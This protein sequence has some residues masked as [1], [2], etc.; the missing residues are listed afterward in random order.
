MDNRTG[1]SN[2]NETPASQWSGDWFVF[3]NG[4]I[5]GPLSAIQAFSMETT[6][7]QGKPLLISKKGFTQWYALKELADIF[8]VT[9]D[10]GRR[11]DNEKA[12]L[13]QQQIIANAI[14]S[15]KQKAKT[16]QPEKRINEI[17]G[18]RTDEQSSKIVKKQLGPQNQ[19]IVDNRPQ[20][21][22]VFKSAIVAP[23]VAKPEVAQASVNKAAEIK[24]P[25]VKF[26]EIKALESESKVV[27]KTIDVKKGQAEEKVHKPAVALSSTPYKSPVATKTQ[28]V[29][30]TRKQLL[31]EY[32][33]IRGRLRLGKIRSP[34]AN[35]FFGLPLSCGLMWPFW[36]GSLLK[37]IFYHSANRT[38]FPKSVVVMGL[39]PGLHFYGVYRMAQLVREMEMQNRYKSVSPLL[40]ATFAIFPPF[41]MAY[42]QDA[43]N[44]HWLLH[45]RHVGAPKK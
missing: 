33:F 44:R 29:E 32:F 19:R 20:A 42:L 39:I 10:L 13:S 34:W 23:N 16:N 31:Q 24:A 21:E 3:N 27:A 17:S 38:N 37:E 36:M 25:D 18:K 41:A 7:I 14:D 15:R 26:P 43:A 12:A 1:T 11:V 35:A 4:V 2:Q 40:A 6:D 28:S 5:Q 45:A 9:D 30:P 8:K 22:V